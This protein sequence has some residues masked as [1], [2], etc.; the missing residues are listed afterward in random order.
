MAIEVE[1]PD[2]SVVEFPDGTANEVIK[3][4]M[5]KHFGSPTPKAEPTPEQNQQ[6]T[7]AMPWYTKAAKA[8]AYG[9]AATRTKD[10]E[11]L[12]KT[13]SLGIDP[14]AI[15]ANT[16]RLKQYTGIQNYD[17]ASAHF[18][19]SSKPWTE[20][21]G[22]LPR[23]LLE[24]T[25]EMA[26]HI[27]A[28]TVAGPLGML[29]S[30][31]LSRGGEAVNAVRQ[32]DNTDPNVELTPSQKLR[33]GGDVAIQSI[34]NEIGGRATL[35]A[36][37][38]V[39]GVG[40]QAVKQAGTNVAKAAATDAAV[41]A[42][43]A[44]VDKALLEGKE[45]TVADLALPGLAG[46]AVGTAFRA[47]GAARDAAV[48]TRFRSLGNLDPQSRGE[49]A[50]T[51]GHYKG[52]FEATQKHF[53]D[54]LAEA[55]KGLD[56]DTHDILSKAKI[57]YDNG[58]RIDPA[59]IEA[60]SKADPEA[61]RVLRNLD[62][63]GVM[64]SLDNGGLS[65]SALGRML[66]PFQRGATKDAPTAL[67]RFAEG[68]SLGHMFWAHDPTTAAAVFGTQLGGSLG[69]K[70]IDAL[71]G[72]SNPAKVITDK[73][74]GT[75]E[76]AQTVAQAKAAARADFE[77]KR[78]QERQDALAKAKAESEAAKSDA[79][80][81]KDTQAQA[82]AEQKAKEAEDKAKQKALDEQLRNERYKLSVMRNS[83]EP[84]ASDATEALR[85]A[86][87]VER[88]KQE[89]ATSSQRENDAK[90]EAVRRQLDLMNNSNKVEQARQSELLK[91]QGDRL[92]MMQR[93]E[94][95][96]A[97]DA[98][99]NLRVARMLKQAEAQREAEAAQADKAQARQDKADTKAAEKQAQAEAKAKIVEAQAARKAQIVDT[100]ISQNVPLPELVS[101]DARMALKVANLKQKNAAKQE[102]SKVKALKKQQSEEKVQAQAKAAQRVKEAGEKVTKL[103]DTP[104]PEVHTIKVH[105][106][107]ISQPKDSIGNYAGWV[108][109]VYER[110]DARKAFID[111]AKDTI[112]SGHKD[113]DSLFRRWAKMGNSSEKATKAF[114]ELLNKLPGKDQSKLKSL[115]DKHNITDTF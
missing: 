109:G 49:V 87:G 77:A 2:G 78:L 74:G 36:T 38:P 34:L 71:T 101:S 15:D 26:Q 65:G 5:A 67:G 28:S 31:A 103:T 97:T 108:N 106:V 79:Q 64:Q 110:M 33:V 20:R 55:K 41:G 100:G 3:G 72:A 23:A 91:A 27:A 14:N 45:P 13:G 69:L 102:Q 112:S 29:G 93:S 54:D 16:E 32:A 107:E 24:G 43:G 63:L 85:T 59:K 50:D 30:T 8:L 48:A 70:G 19:D 21:I 94:E 60:A 35:G 83:Q 105:G 6:S 84:V 66:N 80:K 115:W 114:N 12:R 90:L 40:M 11:T 17:P 22:Y 75:A 68:A 88:L 42:Y 98:T 76:P 25:P 10:A 57:E 99:L 47:P 62:T 56:A 9:A 39:T 7:E 46:A 82:K 44:G 52:S 61:G 18:A 95:A 58:Q 96:S 86:R 73:F 37:K 113:L 1:G 53:V 111:E 4:A 51:L 81:L 104:R 92:A 89:A